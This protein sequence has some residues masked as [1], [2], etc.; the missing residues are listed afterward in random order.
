MD[1]TAVLDTNIVLYLLGGRLS[2]PLPG[3]VYAI[4]VITEMEVL[5]YPSLSETEQLSVSEFF[6][7]VITV[8]LTPE[9][10][11]AAI[12]L[13]REHPPPAARCD[14]RRDGDL[15]EHGVAH[16][17]ARLIGVP[18]LKSRSLQLG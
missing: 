15:G 1:I 6:A 8:D 10:R 17:D 9:V 7:R 13:R 18:G 3:G 16:H 11:S 5:S 2:A 14:H 4:S 12:R